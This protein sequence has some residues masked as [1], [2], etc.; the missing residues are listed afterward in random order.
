VRF[1]SPFC[2]RNFVREVFELEKRLS[3]RYARDGVV[4][5]AARIQERLGLQY[6]KILW[7]GLP[8]RRQR[9]LAVKCDKPR[10]VGDGQGKQINVGELPRPVD[11]GR[12]NNLQIQ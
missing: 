10:L 11:S 1:T 6:K 3:L 8:N 2:T 4:P 5:M 7:L 9:D 12:V